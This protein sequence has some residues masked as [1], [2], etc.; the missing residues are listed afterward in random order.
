[1]TLTIDTDTPPLTVHPAG[2]IYITGTRVSLDIVLTAYLAGDSPE[3]I[4]ESYPSLVLGD[5][6]AAIA[7]YL[8]HRDALN[9]YLD[10]QEKAARALQE[11]I[12]SAP[13][14]KESIDRLL[15]RAR[16]KGML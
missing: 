16:D 14:Y 9:I 6:Y 12:Q 2:F 10:E 1:M 3:E 5:V 15:Q 11:Q 13:G 8:H 4:V 7:Y